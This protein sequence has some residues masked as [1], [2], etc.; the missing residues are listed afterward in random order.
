[1]IK[2]AIVSINDKITSAIREQLSLVENSEVQVITDVM[3][4]RKQ[5]LSRDYDLIFIHYPLPIE[6]DYH[7]AFDI[8]QHSLAAIVV[9]LPS[10]IYMKKAAQLQRSGIIPVS[11]P[12]SVT[13]LKMII[14]MSIASYYHMAGIRE[15]TEQLNKRIVDLRYNFR[16]KCLLIERRGMSEQE[17]HRYIEKMAMNERLTKR[18]ACLNIICQLEKEET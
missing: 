1:M 5:L 16:A 9:F 2:V 14:E 10:V 6:K 15:K 12:V 13:Q 18:D 7:L 3:Q 8:S 4:L 17:A 11:K